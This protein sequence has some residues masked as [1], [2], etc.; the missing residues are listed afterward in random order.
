MFPADSADSRRKRI[1]GNQRYLR[2]RKNKKRFP[3]IA[4]INAEKNQRKSARSAGK[5][6]KK[7][8][9]LITQI[10]AEKNQRKSAGSAGEKEQEMFPADNTE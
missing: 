4:Q 1:S 3:Q 8:F 6:N 2:E 5:E 9:L 7:C 10:N